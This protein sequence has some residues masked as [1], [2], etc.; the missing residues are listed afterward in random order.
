MKKFARV[1]CVALLSFIMAASCFTL[2]ACPKGEGGDEPDPLVFSTGTLDNVFNPFFHTSAYDSEITGQTQISML[3]TSKDGT[4]ECGEDDPTVAYDYRQV[5]TLLDES[6]SEDDDKLQ[7]IDPDAY[8]ETEFYTTYEFLIKNNIKFSD[9]KDL[10]IK[11]VIFNLYSYLDPAYYGSSTIYSTNISGLLAYRNQDPSATRESES[12]NSESLRGDAMEQINDIRYVYH[13]DE[14]KRNQNRLASKYAVGGDAYNQ[15][16]RNVDKLRLLL[17][18]EITSYYA[19]SESSLETYIQQNNT[20]DE[21]NDSKELGFTE[22]WEVFLYDMGY[23]YAPTKTNGDIKL[24]EPGEEITN[25]YG[26]TVAYQAGVDVKYIDY[27]KTGLWWHDKDSLIKI[28]FN[29]L[30]SLNEND[31]NY[32]YDA[33]VAVKN[34]ADNPPSPN[35]PTDPEKAPV[36]DIVLDQFGKAEKSSLKD[37]SGVNYWT[38][39]WE[40]ASLAS[41]ITDIIN[42]YGAGNSLYED[43][44]A[45][46][47]A[48]QFDGGN[49]AV[50]TIEGIK[51]IKLTNGDKFEGKLHGTK[52]ITEDQY[53]LQIR[54]DKVDPKAIWN[55]AFSVAPMHYYSNPKLLDGNDNEA[56]ASFKGFGYESFN[57]PVYKSDGTRMTN[58]GNIWD[59]NKKVSVGRLFGSKDYFDKVVKNASIL[60][61]PVGAGMYKVSKRG[62]YDEDYAE[63]KRPKF[64][65]FCSNNI[66]YFI[67]NPYFYTT[68]GDGKDANNSAINNCYIKYIRYQVIATD[69]VLDSILNGT[70]HYGDPTASVENMKRLTER[71]N[72]STKPSIDFREI[73]NNGYGYVGINPRY[74]P[75]VEI[76]KAIMYAMDLDMII[77]YYGKYAEKLYRPISLES[78]ASPQN[79]SN[80]YIKTNPDLLITEPKYAFDKDTTVTKANIMSCISKAGYTAKNGNGTYYRTLANGETH[81]L[82]YTFTIAGA[83]SDHPAFNMMKIARDILNECGFEVTLVTD[84]N[85]LSKLAAGTLAIWAAAWSSTIDP[86]MYQ[87]YHKDSTSSSTRGWGYPEILTDAVGVYTTEAANIEKLSDLIDQARTVLSEEKR[88]EYYYEAYETVMELAVELPTYQRS[89]IFVYNKDIIDDSTFL[90]K[91]QTSS[92]KGPMSRFWEI[93]MK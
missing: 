69:K 54:V 8:D 62:F 34:E 10:T 14:T 42:Y 28:V 66:V 51:I 39:L 81:E 53:V 84:N 70:V 48:E 5:I 23:I 65:E 6:Y 13:K 27:R 58:D 44:Y 92:Y 74:V 85:A 49:M 41:N 75:D 17:W 43:I 86:D 18:D 68:S 15:I 20:V 67:R 93:K 21:E 72:S 73:P 11:D 78:W 37:A 76:R 16:V 80:P 22:V 60:S 59:S 38:L 56:Y 1:I 83:S 12:S 63:S 87:V 26:E 9:G 50:D 46:L 40:S 25:K 45:T 19:G 64:E 79:T 24:L 55:F 88:A 52:N 90:P 4:P 77:D 3:S 31:G 61:V 57:Y 33:K 47:R 30:M 35:D 82:K 91:D 7:N 89:N 36:T 29:D 2:T 71:K 32:F